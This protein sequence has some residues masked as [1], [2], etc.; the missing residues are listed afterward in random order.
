[1]GVDI[2]TKPNL[3]PM[4]LSN[5]PLLAL[6]V[7]GEPVEVADDGASLLEVLRDRLGIRSAKDGCSPQGQCGCCTVLVDGA[8]PG[9]VRDPG[10]AG[11][12]AAR[13]PPSTASR[14][15]RDDWA[16]GLLRDRRRASA[17]SAR[18]G[19]IVR[20]AALRAKGTAGRRPAAV[21]R[22]LLA[23]LCRCTGWQTI[24]EAWPTPSAAA[25]SPTR[26][27]EAAASAGPR[28]KA[29]CAQRV[30]PEVALG[31]GGFADDTRPGRRPRRRAATAGRLGGRARRWPRPAGAAGKVQ[32]RRTT[33]DAVPPAR[34][35]AGRLGRDAADDVGRARL[36]RDRRVVVRAG[37]RAGV[38]ARPTAARSAAR[39]TSAAPAAARA[40]AD[41]ARSAGA[42]RCCRGRTSSRLGP[43]RPPVAAGVRAD[44]TGVRPGRRARPGS[45]TADRARWRPGSTVEEV[46]V[47]GPPTSSPLR[48]RR[49]GRGRRSLLR[50][51]PA[52]RPR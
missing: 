50:R 30:G 3:R 40:L 26:D 23:H 45:P 44:G 20:L 47:A 29:A 22:A 12:R 13:S 49:L 1:M 10:P 39:S 7:D 33:V 38:A 17:G 36:P 21:E 5:H 32:G 42:G 28:S 37:R 51:P 2:S 19:I 43:K 6:T 24:V 4:A 27:L 48:G 18:P 11:R 14:R 52:A 34:A 25:P 15:R 9:G 35:A 8:A 46:D 41:R 31:R 16:D